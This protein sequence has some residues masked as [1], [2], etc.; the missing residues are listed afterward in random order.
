MEFTRDMR[1]GQLPTTIEVN[2]EWLQVEK[3]DV[4]YMDDLKRAL[5]W[6]A[7]GAPMIPEQ[8]VTSGRISAP[9]ASIETINIINILIRP[10]F[11]YSIS[12]RQLLLERATT[13]YLDQQVQPL[14]K[15]LRGRTRSPANTINALTSVELAG[16]TLHEFLDHSSILLVPS[17]SSP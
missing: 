8:M 13:L 5:S 10:P 1:Q 17:G 6:T 7:S 15:W 12:A 9:Y 4:L 3:K 16:T 14:L 2:P 11:L